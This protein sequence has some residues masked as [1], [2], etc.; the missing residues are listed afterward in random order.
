MEQY[1]VQNI[2]KKKNQKGKDSTATTVRFLNE[3]F[4]LL[5]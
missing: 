3:A 1:F 4:K 2:S 5:G